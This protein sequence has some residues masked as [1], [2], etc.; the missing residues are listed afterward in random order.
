METKY[1]R[2][3]ETSAVGSPKKKKLE[4]SSKRTKRSGLDERANK[5][6]EEKKPRKKDRKKGPTAQMAE[7]EA[8]ENTCLSARR[9]Q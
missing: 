2:G 5:R 7:K 6:S 8:A 4:K 9:L 1:R 3:C